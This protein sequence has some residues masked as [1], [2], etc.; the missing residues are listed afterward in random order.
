M[1]KILMLI[2]GKFSTLIDTFMQNNPITE[3]EQLLDQP[4]P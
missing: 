4:A 1:L 3:L 2:P